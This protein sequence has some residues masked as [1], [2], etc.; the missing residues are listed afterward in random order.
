MKDRDID[1]LLS[2]NV[3]EKF[4]F[5]SFKALK[6]FVAE[7][8]AFWTKVQAKISGNVGKISHYANGATY[9][10][11][12]SDY[13]K[14]FEASLD[15][16]DNNTLQQQIQQHIT[17]N[18]GHLTQ[19]WI[20]STHPF[21]IVWLDVFE[22]HGPVVANTFIQ[23]FTGNNQFSSLNTIDQ[24]KGAVLAYEFELQDESTLTKRRNAEKKSISQVR[25]NLVDAQNQLF[26]DVQQFQA[27]FEKWDEKTRTLFDRFYKLRK[28]LCERQIK[29][30]T[31]R[32]DEQM[33][34]WKQNIEHLES[35]YQEKL[36]LE[37]P[38]KY[39]GDKASSYFFHGIVWSVLLGILLLLG[40]LGFG[41]L[42]KSWLI[43][44]ESNVNLSSLQGIILFIT[45]LSIYAFF[46][47]ALS[48]LAFSS[49][50]LQRDAE[51]REQLT[52]VYLALTHERKDMDVEARNIVLQ[53]LFSRADTGLLSGDSG[54]TMP[55]LHEI[56]KASNTK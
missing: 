50:H 37:K 31:N 34:E 29:H 28:K 3:G 19:H 9:L 33:S 11:Q 48:K 51:E 42:F 55:G 54:P 7:E 25:N 1:V 44:L 39:W 4:P 52:H 56:M 6:K 26:E 43:G 8:L 49:F 18:L 2:D 16:W 15:T 35:T 41:W 38:A 23:A 30:H 40:L 17:R 32:F 12:I 46:I 10:K 47:K 45:V 13:L 27:S 14:N 22:D 53:A 20:W 5:K 21:C 24:L 36:R